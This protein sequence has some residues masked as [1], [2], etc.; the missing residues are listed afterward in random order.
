MDWVL[1]PH[2]P[3]PVL[4]KPEKASLWQ[5]K[6]PWLAQTCHNS[7]LRAGHVIAL[8]K[9]EIFSARKKGERV[10]CSHQ[11]C[12][13]GLKMCLSFHNQVKKRRFGCLPQWK[14]NSWGRCWC[15]RKQVLF[16][17]HMT[18]E[19]GELTS[20]RPIASPLSQRSSLFLLKSKVLQGEEGEGIFFLSND[21]ARSRQGQAPSHSYF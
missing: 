18:W 12:L 1:A 7:S 8:N 11:L 13:P 20:Q 6:L 2:L 5:R 4:R 3:L 10:L 17:S 16:R 14:P 19:N 15:K 9:T 21:L